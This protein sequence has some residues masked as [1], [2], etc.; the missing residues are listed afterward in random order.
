MASISK[1]IPAVSEM[2]LE[3]IFSSFLA[4]FYLD[5]RENLRKG[6]L[7]FHEGKFKNDESN[8]YL[9]F[10][11]LEVNQKAVDLAVDSGKTSLAYNLLAIPL[12]PKSS[13]ARN[14]ELIEAI[15]SADKSSTFYEPAYIRHLID[16][17]W[18]KS[19]KYQYFSLLLASV[20]LGLC[21]FH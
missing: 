10:P 2:V 18:R 1:H 5:G 21:G 9:L 11:H 17:F 13:F 12:L 8:A 19:M 7:L 20:H 14:L 16:F 4:S 15:K 6:N 3:T